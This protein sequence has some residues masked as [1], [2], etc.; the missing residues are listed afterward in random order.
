MF[1][2][3]KNCLTRKQVSNM[4]INIYDY[5][6]AKSGWIKHKCTVSTR[7]HQLSTE[8]TYPALFSPDDSPEIWL[9]SWKYTRTEPGDGRT[10]LSLPAAGGPH[11]CHLGIFEPNPPSGLDWELQVRVHGCLCSLLWAP[12]RLFAPAG[13][14]SVSCT[15]PRGRTLWCTVGPWWG[16]WSVRWAPGSPF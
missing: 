5:A 12:P 1:Y 15:R 2:F 3:L 14:Q 13:R 16:H 10:A 11:L 6:T 7:C 8:R 4:C 9:C